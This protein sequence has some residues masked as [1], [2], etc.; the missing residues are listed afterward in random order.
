ML[1]KR[2][3]VSTQLQHFHFGPFDPSKV[4]KMPKNGRRFPPSLTAAVL[5]AVAAVA[6]AGLFRVGPLVL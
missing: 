2:I 1:E 4:L 5:V 3:E 6:A